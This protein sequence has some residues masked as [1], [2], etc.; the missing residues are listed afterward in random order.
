MSFY[1]PLD[2]K[3]ITPKLELHGATD[4]LLMQL[5]PIVR[6]G[7]VGRQSDPFDDP[8]SLYED[9]PVREWKWLQA[10]WRGRG[11][12]RPES[13]RLYFVVL[14]DKQAVGMQDLIGVN[15]DTFKTVT[16]FSWLAPGVR[17]QGLGREMRAA[18]LHLAFE[19]LGAAEA[20]SDAFF[21]NVASNRVSAALGYQP[22]GS[23]WATRRGQ[24]AMLNRWRLTR[25]VWTLN[26]RSDI[27]LIDVEACKPLLHI[28]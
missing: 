9:N 6:E 16:S 24:P 12:V 1:P 10:I 26:R 19:G 27:E 13:W 5:L 17:Q 3:V 4:D 22:N 15:F 20:G 11:N 7:V 18:I 2:V 14:L 28:T 23:D 25:D 8:M 21:D